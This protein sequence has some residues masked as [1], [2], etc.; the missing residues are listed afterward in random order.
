M[1][2]FALLS[3]P[4]LFEVKPLHFWTVQRSLVVL[5]LVVIVGMGTVGLRYSCQG[6]ATG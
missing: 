6:Q 2:G 3:Q 5:D 4:T 1:W